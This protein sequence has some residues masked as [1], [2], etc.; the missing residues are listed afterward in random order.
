ML[1]LH[2]A[3]ATLVDSLALFLLLCWFYRPWQSSVVSDT[4]FCLLQLRARWLDET[5]RCP[6]SR[7]TAG[8]RLLNE[9]LNAVAL[10]APRLTVPALLFARLAPGHDLSASRVRRLIDDT[11]VTLPEEWLRKSA[12]DILDQ[13]TN[14]LL[15]DAYRRSLLAMLVL[16]PLV[17]IVAAGCSTFN[18][19]RMERRKLADAELMLAAGLERGWTKLIAT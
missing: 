7:G 9:L 15:W 13:M 10:A 18:I 8:D 14:Q 5:I 11:F 3:T 17:L 16:T 1:D 12:R 19:L 4:Q 6:A 2:S